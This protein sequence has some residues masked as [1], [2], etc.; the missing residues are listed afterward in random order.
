MR[1][2]PLVPA[3]LPHAIQVSISQSHLYM[4]VCVCVCVYTHTHTVCVCVCVY[5]HTHTHTRRIRLGCGCWRVWCGRRWA[6]V[7]VLNFTSNSLK[8][9]I[10]ACK[11][12][13]DTPSIQRMSGVRC[14]V[15]GVRERVIGPVAAL[16]LTPYTTSN[17]YSKSNTSHLTPKYAHAIMLYVRACL[18]CGVCL[19][20]AAA[21]VCVLRR[22]T[23]RVR[24]PSS[25][26]SHRERE[27]ERER[28]REKHKRTHMM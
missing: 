19:S 4:Y 13:A 22:Q 7:P 2:S 25:L 21:C 17:T 8:S 26:L 16:I 23:V 15:R 12:L 18:S 20:L 10:Y 27:T 1:E 24:T 6:G 9:S 11:P 28:Q 14:H 5:T 3:Q